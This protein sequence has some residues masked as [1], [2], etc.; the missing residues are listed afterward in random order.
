MTSQMLLVGE[1]DR[2]QR[3]RGEQI[4]VLVHEEACA[5]LEERRGKTSTFRRRGK[6]NAPACL[7]PLDLTFPGAELAV[8]FGVEPVARPAAFTSLRT[9]G[10]LVRA[11][12]NATFPDADLQITDDN[13]AAAMQQADTWRIKRKQS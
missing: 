10:N 7:N 9:I 8:E 5:V 11:D 1:R 2:L 12:R 4:E 3:S 13:R 6:S